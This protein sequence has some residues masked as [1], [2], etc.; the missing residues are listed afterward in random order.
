M[1]NRDDDEP[2]L[3]GEIMDA[4]N[5]IADMNNNVP[6]LTLDQR[7]AMLNSD[8]KRIYDKI[9]QHLTK[10]KQ[11]EDLSLTMMSKLMTFNLYACLV[12]AWEEQEN[13]SSLKQ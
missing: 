10:K 12:V 5:D 13:C 4:V 3:L 9:K 1:K 11:Q 2:Q 6:N 8:Q 7:V